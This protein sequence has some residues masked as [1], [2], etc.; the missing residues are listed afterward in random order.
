MVEIT[1]DRYFLTSVRIDLRVGPDS[2]TGVE[3]EVQILNA[4]E[5]TGP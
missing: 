3:T 2:S 4:P 1:I 5:V